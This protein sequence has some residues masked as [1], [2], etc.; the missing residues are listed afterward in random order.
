MELNKEN[1][2]KLENPS[3]I[4]RFIIGGKA[5]ITLESKRTGRWFTYR[6]KKAKKDE[7]FSPFFVSVL[8]GGDNESSYTYMGTIFNNNNKFNFT[9][10]KNSK[11][12]DDALSYKAFNF[13]FNLV[14]SDKMH[15]E[16][17]VYHRGICSVCGRTLTTP[18]SIRTGIGPVC[19]GR[20]GKVLELKTIRKQKLQKINRKL[21]K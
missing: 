16:I 19:D 18:D 8:T 13:L 3:D 11:I 10:T 20:V 4:K 7:E 14:N 12:G 6:I 15:E 17:S 5:I 21:V 9:L 1:I 2:Y